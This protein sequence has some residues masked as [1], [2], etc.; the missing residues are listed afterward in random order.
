MLNKYI[1]YRLAISP[2]DR[3]N[4]MFHLRCSQQLRLGHVIRSNHFGRSP[5]INIL[6]LLWLN[7]LCRTVWGHFI[8][9]PVRHWLFTGRKRVNGTRTQNAAVLGSTGLVA[10]QWRTAGR[11]PFYLLL[12]IIIMGERFQV[13]MHSINNLLKLQKYLIVKTWENMKKKKG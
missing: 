1:L 8:L 2:V 6:I 5:S 12:K 11:I 7:L 4:D 13:Q 10:K 3:R 9:V